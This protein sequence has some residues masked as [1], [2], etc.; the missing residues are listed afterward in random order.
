MERKNIIPK[1]A[2]NRNSIVPKY[3]Q[4]IQGILC[5]M[6]QGEIMQHDILPS[7]HQLCTGLEVSRN[8]VEKAYGKLKGRGIVG[9]IHGKGYY[10]IA[11]AKNETITL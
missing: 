11:S 2:I 3:K 7:I 6:E 4:L 10:I 8:T 5:I 1:L 9:S